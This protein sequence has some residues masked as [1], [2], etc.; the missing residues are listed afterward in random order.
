MRAALEP[1]Q[2][3]DWV[4]S[5]EGRTQRQVVK[6][7]ECGAIALLPGPGPLAY[8]PRC[9][10]GSSLSARAD[11]LAIRPYATCARSADLTLAARAACASPGRR[12]G[13]RDFFRLRQPRDPKRRR[14]AFSAGIPWR[15][16]RGSCKRALFGQEISRRRRLLHVGRLER[17]L[18]EA[19]DYRAERSC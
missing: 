16:R 3:P 5:H 10:H 9:A 11:V 17:C 7:A 15:P 1:T 18:S 6:Q 13:R 8:K 4:L 19:S 14:S 2:Q 12:I